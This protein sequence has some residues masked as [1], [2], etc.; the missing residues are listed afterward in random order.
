[1]EEKKKEYTILGVAD[2]IGAIKCILYDR[3][4]KST[5][6]KGNSVILI[7]YIYKKGAIVVHN[8][9]QAVQS[10]EDFQL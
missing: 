5:L 10:H 9:N 3:T 4:N 7:N 2:S 6:Q 1:M 8:L